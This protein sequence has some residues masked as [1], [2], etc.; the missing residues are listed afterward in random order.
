MNQQAPPLG[1]TTQRCVACGGTSVWLDLD[2]CYYCML[3]ARLRGQAGQAHAADLDIER[4]FYS[5][6]YVTRKQRAF[7]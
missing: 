3:C 5:R 6:Q 2:G 7:S 1:T 4:L